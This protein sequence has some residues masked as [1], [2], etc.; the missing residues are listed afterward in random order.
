[1]SLV[2]RNAR[3]IYGHSSDIFI[4][5]SR[6]VDYL[7]ADNQVIDAN[8]QLVLPGL[9]DLH[10]HLRE[11][12]GEEA[13]TI[14]SGS[15]AAAHGG[16]TCV[17][18]MANTDPV[19][20]SVAKVQKIR[21][22]AAG[23][24]AQVEVI[25]AITEG[26]AGEKLTDIDALAEAG[27]NVFSDDGHCVM[28][29]NVMRRALEAAAR[30]NVLIAQ[31][32]QDHNLAG[33]TACADEASIAKQLGLAGWPWPAE[34]IIIARDAMLAELTGARVH[35]CHVSTA[36][37]V[38]VVRWAKARGIRISAEVTP[39]HLLLTSE[40][41]TSLDTRFKVNPP[42]RGYEDVEAV[43]AGLADGTIDIV[44]TDHAPHSQVSKNQPFPLAK[45][46]MT[47]LEQAL[48]V[49]IETMIK[50]GLMGWDR[51]VDVM[52]YQPAY[53]GKAKGQGHEIAVGQPA[54]LVL[55]DPDRRCLVEAANSVS[56]GINNPYS[57]L[58]L[59]DP[60]TLTIKNGEI[61]YRR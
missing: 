32:C 21:E 52:S 45:P 57:G 11:P 24:S 17:F 23:A 30:N 33:A 58:E 12:G 22:K 5:G 9:V 37:S 36:Q 47:G 16:Y 20:D 13:E 43:R 15:A 7:P 26:L 60:I 6:F 31:H 18:A 44:G 48:A 39:H 10:T 27:V 41:L 28:D 54:N 42:L 38:E 14:A 29:A 8:G 35:A 34:A 46:G 55:I 19:T 53:L 3:D 49:V 40:R 59:P 1:M 56:K 50:P 61:T 25:A 51:L 2:I 4:A